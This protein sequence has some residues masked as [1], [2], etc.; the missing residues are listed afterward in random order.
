ML[1]GIRSP[2]RQLAYFVPDIDEAARQHSAVFGSGPFFAARHIALKSSFYRGERHPFD[3]S[4]AYGQ[5][6]DVMVEFLQ[7]NG[8]GPSACHDLFPVGSGRYGLHHAAM[9]VEDIDTA[10]EQ[11][12]ADGF[13]LAQDCVTEGGTRF[14]FVDTSA[15]LGHMIELYEPTTVLVGFYDMVRGAAQDWDGSAPIRELGA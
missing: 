1:A 15:A 8:D 12:E 14:A 6:G 13:A 10:I 4:S 2:V 7:Q 9:I 3:H 11:F 5:W